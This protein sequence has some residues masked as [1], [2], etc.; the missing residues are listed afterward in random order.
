MENMS[1]LF[2]G[3]SLSEYQRPDPKSDRE[4][5]AAAGEQPWEMIMDKKHFK[6]WRR[7]IEGTHLYQYRGNGAPRTPPG[8][9]FSSTWLVFIGNWGGGK[10]GNCPLLPFLQIPFPLRP[11]E[12]SRLCHLP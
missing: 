7:P 9:C 3:S 4:A 5:V 11:W 10:H 1:S 2:Q 12:G 6:L 8:G